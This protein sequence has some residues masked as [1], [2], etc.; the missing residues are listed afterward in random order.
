MASTILSHPSYDKVGR[1]TIH[2]FINKILSKLLLQYS[3]HT[4]Y[5][6]CIAC[7]SALASGNARHKEYDKLAFKPEFNIV[8]ILMKNILEYL[9]NVPSSNEIKTPKNDKVPDSTLLLESLIALSK[10]P[11][12]YVEQ[13]LY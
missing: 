1:L 10:F 5:L 6:S 11:K 12:H 3:H 4:I 7:F 9:N 13:I 2:V 8:E